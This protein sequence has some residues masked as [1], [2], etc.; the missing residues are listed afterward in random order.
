MII[1]ELRF[2][3]EA[4]SFLDSRELTF[5]TILPTYFGFSSTQPEG[6][7]NLQKVIFQIEFWLFCSLHPAIDT[8]VILFEY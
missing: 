3:I 5:K 1:L 6:M 7:P 2:N 4:S 8:N